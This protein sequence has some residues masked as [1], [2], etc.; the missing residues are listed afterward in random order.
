[1]RCLQRLRRTLAI[2]LLALTRLACSDAGGG[3][4]AGA[5]EAVVRG[6]HYYQSVCT[7]CH[8]GDPNVDGTLGP[9]LA[10]AA[11]EVIEA[12]VMRGVYPEGYTPKRDTNTM[13]S[14]QFLEP[15]LANIVAYLASAESVES[16]EF[17]ESAESAL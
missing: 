15:E 9:A 12:K 17:V 13:P 6:K 8:N 5:S 2:P 7:A 1:M 10:G 11:L 4:D 16:V 14:F 3:E